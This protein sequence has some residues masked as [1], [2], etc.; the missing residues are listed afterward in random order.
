MKGG[1]VI[2]FSLV[3]LMGLM[4]ERGTEVK[5]EGCTPRQEELCDLAA[6]NCGYGRCIE[7]RPEDADL[8][9]MRKVAAACSRRQTR[10]CRRSNCG[11]VNGSCIGCGQACNRRQTRRCR[12]SNCGCVNAVALD[13]DRVLNGALLS[14]DPKE[15]T[16]KTGN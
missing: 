11:C 9:E 16:L 1:V 4:F 6:C 7:C 12:R 10:R 5:A 2:L 13:A 14:D 8:D 15:R 3:V